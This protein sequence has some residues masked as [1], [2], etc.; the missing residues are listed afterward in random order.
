[1]Y[2]CIYV[3]INSHSDSFLKINC[4][5]IRYLEKVIYIISPACLHYLIKATCFKFLICRKKNNKFEVHSEN[6]KR[7]KLNKFDVPH[8]CFSLNN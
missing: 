2:I 3:Y 8:L 1:M 7:G 6:H 4:K 5:I